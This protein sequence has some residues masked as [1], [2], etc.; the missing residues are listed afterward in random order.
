MA[1]TEE[2]LA[3]DL[4]DLVRRSD[5]DEVNVVEAP[6]GGEYVGVSEE[7]WDLPNFTLDDAQQIGAIAADL[8]ASGEWYEIEQMVLK[9][10]GTTQ[11]PDEV[12]ELNGSAPGSEV[13]MNGAKDQH[14]VDG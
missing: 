8:M 4:A 13:S 7:P 1:K 2:G 5:D 6:Y 3:N 9:L 12:A 10:V 14:P 11:L